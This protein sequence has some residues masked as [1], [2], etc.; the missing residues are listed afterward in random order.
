MSN[1]DDANLM[2]EIRPAELEPGFGEEEPVGSWVGAKKRA[3][4]ELKELTQLWQ[5]GVR[6]R[7]EA[8][9][10]GIYRWD[11]PHV[12]PEA[13]GVNGPKTGPT[14]AQLLAVNTDGGSSVRPLRI[15]KTRGEWHPTPGVEFYVDFEFCNDL[16]DDFSKLPEKGGQPLIFMIG[17]GHMENGEWQFKS[18]VADNLSAVEEIRI[19]REWVDHMRL[20]RDRL[21]PQN[22]IPRIFHWSAA[23]PTVLDNAYNSAKARHKSMPIGPNWAGTI[24]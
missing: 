2:M 23:E 12:T 8:H 7:K 10:A 20:V 17:C 3:A 22:G 18:L 6:K 19:I 5:V 13:V 11:D 21:D 15:E 4:S 24:S 16:N 14:L 9:S 1:T